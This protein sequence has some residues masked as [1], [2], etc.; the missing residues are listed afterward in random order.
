VVLLSRFQFALTIMFHYLFPPLTIGLGA[1]LVFLEYRW[2]RTDDP[3]YHHAGRFW[4]KMFGINFALG[5]ATG[6]VMEF[7]FGTNWAVYSRYVGDVFGSA[8][9]A[10]GIFAFFLES[11]FLA[12]LLYG[13]DKVSRGFHFFATCMV[14]L[15]SV[16]SSIWIVVA[17]SWQQTP[18]GSH[19]VEREINGHFFARAEIVDFWAMVFN[20]STVQRLVHVWL[21]AFIVGSFF[22]M[23]ISA[24]YWL[25]GRHLEFAQRSFTGGLLLGTIASLTQLVSGHFNSEMVAHHQPAKLAA[26]EGHFVTGEGGTPLYLAGWPDEDAQTVR[27]GVA[28]PG[29]L[30]FL[31][32]RDFSKPVTGLDQLESDYGRPPV[33][34][35]FQAYHLM[36][37]LGM[38]FIGSTLLACWC[39]MRGTLFRKRWLL[40]FFVVAV[41][42]AFAANEVGWA[43]AEVGRQPWV[44]YPMRDAGG[45]LVGGLRTADGVSEVVT[46]DLVLGSIVM[47]GFI[48]ALLFALWVFLLDRAIRQGPQPVDAAAGQAG[49]GDVLAVIASRA[50]HGDRGDRKETQ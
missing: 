40:W 3:I 26:F 24:W 12:V 34:L 9:A 50:A 4:T 43:A 2:L 22:V 15:G 10:E 29:M 25:R 14:A 32:H 11:G 36:I 48:Y 46:S 13:W 41:I 19:I 7:E 8:L 47:F 18:A 39:W 49:G 44:V 5:V 45:H 38:L 37:G 16:F 1:V 23:S 35:V 21:G 33:W 6:I 30:S 27:G 17:N 20:P 28:I 31:V 42:P